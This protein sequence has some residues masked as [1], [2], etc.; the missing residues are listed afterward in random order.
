MMS[1]VGAA[2]NTGTLTAGGAISVGAGARTG[3][4]EAGA[5]VTIGAGADYGGECE[6]SGC[7]SN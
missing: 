7:P 2:A 6:G 4:I 3:R 1:S 5:A